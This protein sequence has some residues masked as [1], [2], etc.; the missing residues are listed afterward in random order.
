MGCISGTIE[1]AKRSCINDNSCTMFYDHENKGTKFC[2]CDGT[3]QLD[4]TLG[5]VL[6]IKSTVT[7][8]VDESETGFEDGSGNGFEDGSG[9]GF[10]DGSGN[11]V[12]CTDD[13][14]C[15]DNKL[16]LNPGTADAVCEHWCAEI[17]K[18][19]YFG[20]LMVKTGITTD[21]EP[22]MM[23]FEH[24]ND[25][26]SIKVEPGC[27]LTLFSDVQKNAST[28]MGTHTKDKVLLSV[29]DGMNDKVSS[30]KCECGT[31]KTVND[32]CYTQIRR[33]C[34]SNYI[35]QFDTYD[36][37]KKFCSDTP[38]CPMFFDLNGQ[39]TKFRVCGNPTD[40]KKSKVGS[41]VYVKGDGDC[42][43]YE[44]PT[45]P[46]ACTVEGYN[47]GYQQGTCPH[48][49]QRCRLNGQCA[50]DYT[51]SKGVARMFGLSGYRT[52]GYCPLC[53]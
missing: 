48:S 9:N 37:A 44:A 25:A 14:D 46:I 22:N 24:D 26:S 13:S 3:G 18:H 28:L 51:R 42:E 12:V 21:G 40:R 6:Y 10:E 41:V 29:E 34:C 11:N 20:D 15:D 45:G 1:S 5:T 8:P 35:K 52:N 32:P 4:S 27:T 38:T 2:Y 36:A 7:T 33:H 43:P 39:G 47:N 50:I 53:D 16:C 30:Y 49:Y 23:S 17:Y 19:K 31:P